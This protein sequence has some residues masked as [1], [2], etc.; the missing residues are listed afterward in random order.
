M[1]LS[2]YESRSCVKS[3]NVVY[4]EYNAVLSF[5]IVLPNPSDL[6]VLEI[7]SQ[8]IGSFNFTEKEQ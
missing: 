8:N 6:A 7:V 1:I 3:P 4:Y 5:M 2:S